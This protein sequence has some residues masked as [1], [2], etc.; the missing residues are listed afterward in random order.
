MKF[1]WLFLDL[2][3]PSGEVDASLRTWSLQLNRR[4]VMSETTSYFSDKLIMVMP[5][6]VPLNPLLKFIRPLSIPV[7]IAL[8]VLVVVATL[9]IL[10][11]RFIPKNYYRMIIGKEMRDEFM[12]ILSGFVGLS[13]NSLPERNFPR[14]LL[15]MFLIFCLVIRSLYLGSLFNMLKSEI[16]SKEFTTIHEFYEAG[17]HFYLYETLA[18]RVDYKEINER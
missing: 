14:F 16:L 4:K 13:Q 9:V 15:V 7:W 11:A 2:L 1:V 18:Q 12:N 3:C 17:F 10:L 8:A 6:P 5:L